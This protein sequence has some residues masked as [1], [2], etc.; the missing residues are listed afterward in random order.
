MSKDPSVPP[1]MVVNVPAEAPP[2]PP[3]TGASAMETPRPA[4]LEKRIERIER[5]TERATLSY[6][7]VYVL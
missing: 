3:L 1:T 7:S 4:Y 2:G 5:T 6:V